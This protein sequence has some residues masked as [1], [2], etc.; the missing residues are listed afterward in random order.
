MPGWSMQVKDIILA[1]LMQAIYGFIAEFRG[2][3]RGF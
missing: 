2:T 1:M 3:P